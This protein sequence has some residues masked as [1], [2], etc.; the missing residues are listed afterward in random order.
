VFSQDSFLGR[1]WAATPAAL[2]IIAG[3]ALLAMLVNELR[4][5]M[6]VVMPI[7]VPARLVEAGLTPEVM[8]LRLLDGID[9][10]EDQVRGEPM[11]RSGAEIAGSQPDFT[12]PI[13]G[14]SLR[15]V[16][17]VLR[18]MLGL[19]ENR[20]TGEVTVDG[21][22][23]RI[24]LRM[25]GR[26]VIADE[27]HQDAYRLVDHAAPSILK[28]TQPSLYAWWLA[29]SAESEA[30][31]Q[32]VL[33]GMLEDSL[34]TPEEARTLRLLLSRSLARS[35]RAAESLAMADAL[36]SEHPQ[37]AVAL[38]GRGRALRDLGR[39]D[40]AWTAMREAQ[41]LLPTAPFVHVGLSQILRDR[42]DA[43]AALAEITPSLQPGRADSQAP[44]EAAMALLQLGRPGEALAMAR[45]AVSQ[46]AKNPSALTALGLALTRLGRPAE[47]LAQFDRAL[48][49]A[50]LWQEARLARIATLLALDDAEAALR[51]WREQDAAIRAV[52]RLRAGAE[53]LAAQM[54][55]AGA[56]STGG[57]AAASTGGAAASGGGPALSPPAAAVPR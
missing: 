15:S 18:D 23:L 26:G 6:I 45:R 29:E 43:A 8:A 51:E 35:G 53:A 46:D 30:R 31:L 37:Y 16:A 19:Q 52:P 48:A 3:M 56:A 55:G 25:N 10:V 57:V 4:R 27:R 41:R 38:Y 39:L 17:S 9:R 28:A 44:T 2:P 32:Q 47:G 1:L 24:R 21:E 42:G 13:A 22:E 54:G 12:V 14:I 40:E 36:L 50:P 7:S 49:E 5:D 11:R 33:G 20:V 34:A